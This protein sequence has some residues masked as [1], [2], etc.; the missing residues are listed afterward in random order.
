MESS[1]SAS[2]DDVRISSTDRGTK[3]TILPVSVPSCRTDLAVLGIW[4]VQMEALIHSV[5]RP[6][7]ASSPICSWVDDECFDADGPMEKALEEEAIMAA[8]S[9]SNAGVEFFIFPI[10][11]L[12]N[13]SRSLL[14]EKNRN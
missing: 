7:T 8:T 13:S 6:V 14:T 2:A 11:Q 1:P 3:L 9:E 12:G 5:L 4:F 10:I